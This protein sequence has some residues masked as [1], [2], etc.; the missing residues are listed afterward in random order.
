MLLT[1]HDRWT[2]PNMMEARKISD[3]CFLGGINE[4]WLSTAKAGEISNH[5]K[6]A[7]AAGRK[8]L[9]ITPGCVAELST[10]EANFQ[11]VKEAVEAL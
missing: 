9:I 11:A 2:K 6:E 10:P 4:K 5:I 8:G 1:W 7:T 3:K